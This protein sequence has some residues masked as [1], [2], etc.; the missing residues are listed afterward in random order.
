MN[1]VVFLAVATLPS[2]ALSNLGYRAQAAIVVFFFY[3][4]VINI[5][6]GDFLV[7]RKLH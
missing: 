6:S 2:S 7:P 1:V 5:L 4:L 3:S